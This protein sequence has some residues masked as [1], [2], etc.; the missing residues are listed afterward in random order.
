M[1]RV[2]SPYIIP[3]F[4]S[5]LGCPF[6]CLYCQQERITGQ[7]EWLPSPEAISQRIEAFLATRK[8]Q[9]YSHTEVAF[10]GG[11]FTGLQP[12]LME[13]MLGA[14]HRFVQMGEVR[15]LRASTKPDYIFRE[16]LKLLLKYQMDTVELGVQ[17]L[18]DG[19]LHGVGRGYDSARVETAVRELKTAGFRVGIQ[20]MQ[21][22]PGADEAEALAS[23]RK[24][25]RLRPDFVRLYPTVVLEDTALA[26]LYRRGDYQPW[27]LETAL[28]VCQSLKNM[29]KAAKIPIIKMGLEFSTDERKGVLAGPYHPRFRELLA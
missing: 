6:H 10:Y 4:I 19:V 18:D 29:F 25:I 23:A 8:P 14:A 24:A 13:S 20:L 1:S 9:K 16:R 22:L 2:K 15:S 12:E 17:S 3:I 5:H 27:S 11:T 7:Q 21:G 26:H 28:S